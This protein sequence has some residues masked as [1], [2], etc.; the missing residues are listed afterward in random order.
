MQQTLLPLSSYQKGWTF[1]ENGGHLSGV[2]ECLPNCIGFQ[3][4]EFTDFSTSLQH[5]SCSIC[6][7]C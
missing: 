4:F 3:K 5:G 7:G 1:W 2:V 6:G